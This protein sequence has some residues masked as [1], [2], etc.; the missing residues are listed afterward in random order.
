MSA[1]ADAPT[2][3]APP[4][5]VTKL[6]L[7][8][9]RNK[10]YDVVVLPASTTIRDIQQH[11]PAKYFERSLCRSLLYLFRDVAQVV[12]TYAA[13]YAVGLPLIAYAESTAAAAAPL[14]TW[15]AA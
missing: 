10:E 2:A 15:L 6:L 1:A 13:M 7:K 14:P 5:D 12:A 4:H 8:A 3:A 9:G 11:V